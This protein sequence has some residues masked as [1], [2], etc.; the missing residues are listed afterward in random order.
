MLQEHYGEGIC[1]MGGRQLPELIGDNGGKS[2]IEKVAAQKEAELRAEVSFYGLPAPTAAEWA[3]IVGDFMN[4][5]LGI[6]ATS[7]SKTAYLF[8]LPVFFCGL[9]QIDEEKALIIGRR[10]VDMFDRDPREQAHHRVTWALMKPGAHFRGELIKFNNGAIR[11]SLSNPFRKQISAF[12]LP[13]CVE[14]TIEE[15]H[16]RVALQKKAHHLGPVRASLANRMPWMERLLMRGHLTV[17]ELI[18]AIDEMRSLCDVPAKLGLSTH[19]AM[20]A[21]QGAKPSQLLKPLVKVVYRCEVASAYQDV[22]DVGKLNLKRKAAQYSLNKKLCKEAESVKLSAD[23]VTR[24]AMKDHFLDVSAEKNRFYSVKRSSFKVEGLMDSLLEPATKRMKLD[25]ENEKPTNNPDVDVDDELSEMVCFKVVQTDAAKKKTVPV[26][27]GAG[28]KLR[29]GCSVIA[30]HKVSSSRDGEICL[31]SLPEGAGSPDVIFVLDQLS[32]SVDEIASEAK[33][34][35]R[36]SLHWGLRGVAIDGCTDNDIEQL[37]SSLMHV[38]AYPGDHLTDGLG[39]T[40][41]QRGGL[42]ALS[43]AGCWRD[44]NRLVLREYR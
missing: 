31:D 33:L 1:M 36:K 21:H 12:R 5:I 15:K 9:A 38:G 42:A 43:G 17:Q 34:W 7:Q 4:A 39:A 29:G 25:F 19:P 18:D 8:V 16:A 6:V 41:S 40:A 3:D 22:S 26:A 24:R 37:I 30:V 11:R 32:G 27:V 28:S 10:I 20:L 13:S 2:T 44:S 23:V 35:E 14:T